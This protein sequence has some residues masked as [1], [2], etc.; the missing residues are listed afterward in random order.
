MLNITPEVSKVKMKIDACK[1]VVLVCEKLYFLFILENKSMAGLK[2]NLT[3][4]VVHDL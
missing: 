2:I 3:K 4:T 1:K